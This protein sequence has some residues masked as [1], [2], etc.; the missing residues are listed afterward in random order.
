[1]SAG[2]LSPLPEPT[3]RAGW[4]QQ[5]KGWSTGSLFRKPVAQRGHYPAPVPSLLA[6]AT[7]EGEATPG[8]QEKAT[9]QHCTKSM[10]VEPRGLEFGSLLYQLCSLRHVT[11]LSGPQF[12]HLE[13]GLATQTPK[14]STPSVECSYM[15]QC[16]RFWW[17][18]GVCVKHTHPTYRATSHPQCMKSCASS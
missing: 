4:G 18:S 11:Y 10:R 13:N 1:M 14:R 8:P 16:L 2:V 12:S 6:R 17:V 7:L 5:V 3:H 15:R 9:W